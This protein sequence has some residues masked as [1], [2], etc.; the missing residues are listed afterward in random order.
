MSVVAE[1]L[2][3]IVRVQLLVRGIVQ[4]VGFRPYVYSLARRNALRGQ[5]LNNSTGVL[6]DVEGEERDIER[7]VDELTLNPPP[8]SQIES[9]QRHDDPAAASFQD[10]RIVESASEGMTR[11]AVS[12]DVATCA[13]C[14]RELFD[15]QDRRHRYPFINCTN[16]GPRFTIV[17]GIPYD[18]ARTTMRDFEMCAACR[19]EYENPLDRRFHA[20]PTACARCGPR[21]SLRD[22]NGHEVRLD[23]GEDIMCRVRLLLAAGKIVVVKGIGGF[24]LACD[25]LNAGAVERL[26]QRKYREDKPF[27]LMAESV[28]VVREFCVVSAEE[29]TLLNSGRRPV[30]LLEKRI[31]AR[32]PEAIAPRLRTLGFMLPYSPL[33]YLLL[34]NLERP[35]V[36]TSGNVSDEPV[37]YE[38]E[39]A[40]RRL[41]KIADYFLFHDRRIHI[42][43]DDSVARVC[44]GREM[45]LRRA[46]GYA[47]APVR[48][49]FNFP[50]QILACGA[51]LKNTFCL[52]RDRHAFISHH[53][54]DLENLETLRS[55]EQGIEHYQRLFQLQPE[56]VAYDLHPEYL[57]TKYAL[58]LDESRTKIGV[59]HHHAHIASCM[60][61]NRIEGEVIGVAMDGL[62]FGTDGR[63]WG[64]EFFVADFLAAERVAHLDYIP[65]PGG[66]KAIREPWRMAA[67]YLHRA[68]GDDFLK[69]EIPFV[70][71]LDGRKWATLRRMAETGTNSPATS[72]MGRLFDAVSGLLELRSVVNYEGQAAI[73]LEASADR[74]DGAQGYEFECDAGGV[75]RADAVIRRAVEDLLDGVSPPKISAKFHLG[76]AGLIASV[77]RKTR[78]ERR[79]NRVALSG[80]VFQNMLLL[81]HVCAMLEADGFEVY[82]HSRV[83]TNDGGISLG[84]AAIAGAHLASGRI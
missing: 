41:D 83:P 65:M 46:R 36:L 13:D 28:A 33:H 78:D 62:G 15:A 14:L 60:A 40:A 7:F 73:E 21:L 48:V 24:H 64:G 61:D 71:N 29:E 57:S 31:D 26:R 18:R 81:S 66:A 59:Q 32:L 2:S 82:T 75:I 12:A 45:V 74:S 55:Y 70:R 67:A 22:Q 6:I 23:A 34:E 76:V 5:V 50:R 69:L 37:C 77:A 1:H 3:R 54:G 49:N 16:C 9:I 4:G 42:R 51:E 27:A 20:E 39:D 11:A 72:S 30:V 84:Q 79:L 56:V 43:T 58:A 80:G 44:A 25:A 47:P 19:A 68:L 35:L 52:A 17:E 8:L 38:D 63:M 10:F 53:I